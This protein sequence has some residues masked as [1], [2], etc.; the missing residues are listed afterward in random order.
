MP[1]DA[2][3][4]VYIMGPSGAGKDTLL[5]HAGRRLDARRAL[6]APRYITRPLP[7]NVGEGD[8]K[9]IPLSEAEFLRR[10]DAGFFALHWRSH[11][12]HYGVSADIDAALE[13]GRMVVVNGSREY[14]PGALRRCPHMLPVLIHARPDV[15][16]ARLLGRGRE[17]GADLAERIQAASAPPPLPVGVPCVRIDNSGPLENALETLLTLLWSHGA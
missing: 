12:L 1:R 7:D 13:H 16:H 17:Q 2:G 6:L 3:T 5:R 15:L 14:L 11:G 4:L 10:R 8:E 9:H